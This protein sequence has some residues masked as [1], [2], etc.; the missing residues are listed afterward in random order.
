MDT[1]FLIVDV[2]LF[3]QLVDLKDRNP[4][5]LPMS[6]AEMYKNVRRAVDLCHCDGEIKDPVALAPEKYIVQNPDLAS[7]LKQLS[8]GGKQVFLLTNSLYDY[9]NVVCTYL[10]G[11]DWL[12]YFDLGM[13]PS[14]PCAPPST[15]L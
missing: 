8:L 7:M 1:E 13:Q 12:D 11:D 10:L 5:L 9:T 15:R 2:C 3:S 6:Y 4:E 14:S